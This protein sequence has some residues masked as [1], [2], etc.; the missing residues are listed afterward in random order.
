MT[1]AQQRAW[2]AYYTALRDDPEATPEER[3]R[4]TDMLAK[5]EV[6]GIDV[7]PTKAVSPS[8]P[9]TK[10]SMLDAAPEDFV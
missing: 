10:P 1:P 7:T 8:A 2:K 9:K 5:G 6:L 4:G 3:Q